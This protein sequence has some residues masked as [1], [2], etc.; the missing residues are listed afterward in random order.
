MTDFY[1]FIYLYNKDKQH[2]VILIDQFEEIYTY[3][4][5]EPADSEIFIDNKG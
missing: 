2:L 1:F 5:I 3:R 4:E